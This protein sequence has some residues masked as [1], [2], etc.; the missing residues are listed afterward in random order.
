MI[1]LTERQTRVVLAL[2]DQEWRELDARRRETTD[3]ADKEELLDKQV[4]V[5]G[6]RIAL[7]GVEVA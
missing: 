6:I 7:R 2:V 1:E 5:D 4:E 3:V